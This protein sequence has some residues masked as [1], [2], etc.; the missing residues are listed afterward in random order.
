[1]TTSNCFKIKAVGNP[2]EDLRNLINLYGGYIK[3]D[4]ELYPDEYWYY[5]SIDKKT[6]DSSTLVEVITIKS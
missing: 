5:T 3:L 6:L 4:A 1:M 2:N